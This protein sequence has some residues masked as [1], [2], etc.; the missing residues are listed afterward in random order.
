MSVLDK[1]KLLGKTTQSNVL[2]SILEELKKLNQ[3]QD[4]K[5]RK[6]WY[7]LCFNF[8]AK[9]GY[10]AD[11][12]HGTNKWGYRKI[13]QPDLKLDFDYEFH[14]LDMHTE[15]KDYKPALMLIINGARYP[16][17]QRFASDQ[18]SFDEW[19]EFQG[20]NFNYQRF[21]QFNMYHTGDSNEG[22]AHYPFKMT[23]K[24]PWN[25]NFDYFSTST[26][27]HFHILVIN[28]WRLYPI[29]SKEI[30]ELII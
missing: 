2:D 12:T 17:V 4:I 3:K 9:G 15:Y 22:S 7:P 8:Y 25:L 23:V 10:V 1:I 19:R 20:H 30:E 27:Y 24:K 29:E 21:F 28:G 11:P 16:N 5:Y 14:S 6:E 18:N 13:D 26:S